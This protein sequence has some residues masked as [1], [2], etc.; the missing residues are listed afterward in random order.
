VIGSL[1]E[2]DLKNKIPDEN[3]PLTKNTN[4]KRSVLDVVLFRKR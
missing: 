3:V 1:Q 2:I 4:E